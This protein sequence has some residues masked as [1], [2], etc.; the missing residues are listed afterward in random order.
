MY[1][2]FCPKKILLTFV[3]YLN[4]WC[5]E[6]TFRICILLYTKKNYFIHS[7]KKRKDSLETL[8]ACWYFCLNLK[9]LGWP[10]REY[11]KTAK[12]SDFCEELIGENNFETVLTTFC[13]YDHG[14]KA[15]EAV[16][17]IAINQKEYHKCSSCVTIS[18]IA[19]LYL[20]INNKLHVWKKVGS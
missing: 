16:Q 5:I 2:L 18:W 7:H 15:S 10:Y 4:V 14:A 6:Y 12:N 20:S 13:C 9:Y 19:K 17:K 11:T 8:A 1:R 3:F